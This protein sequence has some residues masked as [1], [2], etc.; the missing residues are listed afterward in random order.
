MSQEEATE[1]SNTEDPVLRPQGDSGLFQE[2]MEGVSFMPVLVPDGPGVNAGARVWAGSRKR[3]LT[4]E[5]HS[6]ISSQIQ[7]LIGYKYLET[8]KFEY[9]PPAGDGIQP[10]SPYG[11]IELLLPSGRKAHR[12][13]PEDPPQSPALC[14]QVSGE[15]SAEWQEAEHLMGTGSD[16]GSTPSHS[17]EELEVKAQPGYWGRWELG[18][19]VPSDTHASS[20]EPLASLSTSL[21][22]AASKAHEGPVRDWRRSKDAILRRSTDNI[23]NS[24]QDQSEESSPGGCLKLEEV[25]MPHGVK[26]VCYFGSGLVIRLLGAISHSQAGGSQ[27]PK[28]EA[29]EDLMEVSTVS[30]ARRPRTKARPMAQRPTGCQE[31]GSSCGAA[32]AECPGCRAMEAEEEEPGEGELGEDSAEPQPQQEKLPLDVRVRDI[33]VHAIQEVLQSRLQELPHLVLSEEMVGSIAAG[34]E[35]ALFDL[36][37]ETNCRYKTKYRS[38]V[39]NL[40]DPRN[41]DLFLKV[42]RGD[43]TPHSLVRM[44][45][46]QLAPQEL[47]RWREQEEKKGLE[48]IQQQQQEPCSLPATK[49]THKGEVEILRDVDQMLTLEDLVGPMV[50]IDHSP[51]ALPATSGDT[52]EQ[53]EQH[54]LDPNCRICKDWE[55]SGELPDCFKAI[56]RKEDNIF[57]RVPSPSPVSSPEMPLNRERPLTD[58]QDR[59]GARG[60][61][62]PAGSTKTL[63]SQPPWEGTLDMF[64]IKRFRAKA[65]LVSGHSCRLVQ[66]LP[67]V[68]RSAGCIAP[69][70]VWDLLASICPAEAKDISVVKLCPQ[71]ARDT[72]NCRLLYS[73]LNNKQRH[74]LAAVDHMGVVLLPLPAFQPLPARLRPLGG[75]GLEI[76][77]SSLLLAVLLPKAGLPNTAGSSPLRGKVRKMVSFNR[78]VETRCYQPED[79]RQDMALKGSPFPRGALHQSQGNG[80]LAQGGVCAQSK[81]SRGRGRLWGEPEDSQVPARGQWPPE[82]GGCHSWNPFSAAPAGHCFGRGQHLHKPSCP[83]QALLQHLES[84]VTMS[85]QLQ[86]SLWPSGQQLLPS[87]LAVSAQHP[88]APGIPCLPTPPEPLGPVPDSHR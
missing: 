74:C 35:A 9:L 15:V 28:L 85:H 56:R 29:L 79:R 2:D 76:T 21:E 19:P 39:F 11:P 65:Q 14:L 88:E 78:K 50:S 23:V 25:D 63:P 40:R 7:V 67:E 61:E 72:Q 48:I 87:P 26:H 13:A 8:E 75:P 30:P 57:Q 32:S 46:I 6:G 24:N 83:H 47:A 77:H 80:S 4:E 58:T 27:A 54:F 36:T 55:P 71:G 44:S 10:G 62:I 64:S 41:L 82:P 81:P 73:Y 59:Y 84:L 60:W 52:T 68:I 33:V 51:S 53:H 37:Q 43:I 66:A 3:V 17:Q 18:L 31:A 49:L 12:P 20:L 42:V 69:N 22:P 70:T 86:A 34:I 45:S 38:L 1:G 16:E 5:A